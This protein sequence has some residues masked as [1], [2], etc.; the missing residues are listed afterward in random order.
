MKC[1]VLS[2]GSTYW[3]F[4]PKWPFKKKIVTSNHSLKLMFKL[5]SLVPRKHHIIKKK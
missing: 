4:G 5:A 2:L 1:A 3:S